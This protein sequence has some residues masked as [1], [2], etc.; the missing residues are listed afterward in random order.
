MKNTLYVIAFVILNLTPVFEVK[1]LSGLKIIKVEKGKTYHCD[2]KLSK[3]PLNYSSTKFQ[4]ELMRKDNH[5]Q[6]PFE[7]ITTKKIVNLY[8]PKKLVIF[9]KPQ[10]DEGY[11]Y[12]YLVTCEEPKGDD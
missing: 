12:K 11:I 1:S 10:Y 3:N 4:C 8:C 6:A 2:G 7:Y 5:R 9:S